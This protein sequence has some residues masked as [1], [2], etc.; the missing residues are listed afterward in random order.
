MFIVAFADECGNVFAD[1]W[2][3]SVIEILHF[4]M[5]F[6]LWLFWES[7]A[8]ENQVDS[9]ADIVDKFFP[10]HWFTIVTANFGESL[11]SLKPIKANNRLNYFHAFDFT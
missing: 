5:A 7:N 6:H 1:D 10:V 2:S 11:W 9:S 8:M 4:R 3:V